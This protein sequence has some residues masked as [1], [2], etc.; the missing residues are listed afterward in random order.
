MT[1]PNPKR[2]P[3]SDY[4]KYAGMGFQFLAGCLL[5]FLLGQYLDR[6]F[7]T[8]NSVWTAVCTTLFMIAVMGNIFIDV[9]KKK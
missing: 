4:L 6:K 5:G 8:T 7:Q 2:D 9:L 3:K 1:K